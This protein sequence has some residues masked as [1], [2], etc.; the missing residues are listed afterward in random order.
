M[1]ALAQTTETTTDV[2][3]PTV[4]QPQTRTS[5]FWPLLLSSVATGASAT[6]AFA[7]GFSASRVCFSNET[8]RPSP[9]CNAGVF[10]FA[11]AVQLGLNLLIIPELY[12]LSGDDTGEVRLNM[13][14]WMRW[15]ALV[16]AAA[17]VTFLVGAVNETNQFDTGQGAMMWGIGGALA[18][19]ITLDVFAI[20]GAFRGAAR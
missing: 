2:T 6:G 15:P 10:A 20:I 11:G 9:I 5:R 19:G 7:T 1:S 12:R 3:P 16:L 17:A 14:R 13:W 8:G 18:G 4:E